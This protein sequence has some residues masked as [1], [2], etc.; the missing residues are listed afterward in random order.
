LKVIQVL[1]V[2]MILVYLLGSAIPLIGLFGF[3]YSGLLHGMLWTLLTSL[4]VHVDIFHL[5][6]NMFF[7]YVF[8]SAL[9][10]RIG[11]RKTLSIFF[12]GGTSSLVVGIP[13]YAPGDHIV[14]SSIAVSALVG[15]A[16]VLDPD[17]KSMLLLYVPLGLVA[18]I[19]V[20]FNV[21]MFLYDQS[22]GVAWGS[23][24]IGFS[25][26]VLFGIGWRKSGGKNRS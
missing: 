11:A 1:I 18:V 26:G 7:L 13:L 19:Y 6:I 23:H 8:G 16:I 21:F 25:F 3:S 20:I 12:I 5:A 9:E 10:D 24:I 14:G 4:F 2:V 15:A 22:G 17:K